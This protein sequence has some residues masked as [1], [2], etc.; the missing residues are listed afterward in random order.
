MSKWNKPED[1]LKKLGIKFGDNDFYST[2]TL[3]LASLSEVYKHTEYLPKD[4][5][6]LCFIINQLSPVMYLAGQNCYEYN[7]M[8]DIEDPL[9]THESKEYLHTQKCLQ[10]TPKRI[11]IDDEVDAFINDPNS[12]FNSDF[13]VLDLT[14]HEYQIWTT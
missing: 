4:K 2:F 11:Y 7:G 9:K 13:H 6:Q 12:P 14:Q 3:L 5:K 10:I 1:S 8:E